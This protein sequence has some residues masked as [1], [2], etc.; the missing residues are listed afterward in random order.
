MTTDVLTQAREGD[1]QA[2]RTL[3]DPYRREL[4]V[5]C[6]RMLGSAQDAEDALQETMLA[7]WRG[8]DGFEE[9]A[10]L[11][12]WLYR[13]AT[14]RCLNVL[15]DSARRPAREPGR[16]LPFAPP[17]PTR[18]G[19]VLW[20]EPYPDVM[21][22]GLPDAAPG[23]DARLEMRESIGLAFVTAL[24]RLAPR[25]RAVLVLRDVL[26]YRAS[27]VATMLDTSEASVNSALQRARATLESFTPVGRERAPLPSSPR[28]RELVARFADAFEAGDLDRV[29]ALLTEDAWVTMPPEPFEYQGHEAIS[30][31]FGIAFA[32]RW[33]V[34]HRLVPTRANGQPAFGHYIRDPQAAVMRGV[35]LLVLTPEGDRIAQITRFAGAGLLAGFGLPRTLPAPTE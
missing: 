1:E 7:A 30:A 21:L 14:N 18:Y 19:E 12:A 26:G 32:T 10:S 13:I 4:Q 24:Q 17:E 34:R 33:H 25:Q 23:P 11:R 20:L 28:E 2:F 27:E 16:P 31:F 22:E 15:R 29:L 8:L 5:H 9:R 6:Y 35:G 3:T